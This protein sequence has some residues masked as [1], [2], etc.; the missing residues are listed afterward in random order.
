M[1]GRFG[2]VPADCTTPR[3]DGTG[4]LTVGADSLRFY[5]SVAALEAVAERG[6]YWLKARFAYSGEGMEWSRMVTLALRDRGRMLILEEFGDDAVP[7]P[8]TYTRC[9]S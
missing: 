5:E 2:L 8:R 4:L 3:G 9:S 7:G 1:R 6:P